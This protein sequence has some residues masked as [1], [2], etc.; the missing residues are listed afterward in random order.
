MKIENLHIFHGPKSW[1]N[2]A[3][4]NAQAEVKSGLNS[5]SFNYK[6]LLNPIHFYK[7]IVKA[8][9]VHF[10]SGYSFLPVSQNWHKTYGLIGLA[11][12]P[13]LHKLGKKIVLHLQGCE[14][15]DRFNRNAESV[16]K[17]CEIRNIFCRKDRSIARRKRFEKI[18]PYVSA[19]AVTTPDLFDY[20]PVKD[21]SVHFIPK[22]NPL[23]FARKNENHTYLAGG[24]LAILHAPSDR[25][26]KGTDEIIRIIEL[27]S[28]KF[29]LT[30]IENMS[31]E[32]VLEAGLKADVAI[33]QIRVGWYGN[34]AVEMMS[35]GTPTA[36]YINE[37]YVQALN[38]PTPPLF[39]AHGGNLE[40]LLLKLYYDKELLKTASKN[41]KIYSN[42]MHSEE[43][44]AMRLR[45]IYNTIF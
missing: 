26:I 31:R 43:A 17:S 45:N 37:K 20:I 13:I 10:Y 28:D 34:F 32:A 25:S 6:E 24:K 41:V 44:I 27:H 12:I 15:R 23:L 8:D 9:V 7:A 2:T 11:D 3:Q 39:N 33:D 36:A 1:N 29:E 21:R 19:I 18:M 40:E 16:C 42:E 35:L 14:I 22:I 5:Y 38:I 30:L 4:K